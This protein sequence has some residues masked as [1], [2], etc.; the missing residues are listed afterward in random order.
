MRARCIVA[1]DAAGVYI[2]SPLHHRY[3]AVV[4]C[5][6][7]VDLPIFNVKDWKSLQEPLGPTACV[8]ALEMHMFPQYTVNP[9]CRNEIRSETGF[10]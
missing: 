7:A 10:G 2:R 8:Q 4:L 3:L 9:I 6:G 5:Q 1:E